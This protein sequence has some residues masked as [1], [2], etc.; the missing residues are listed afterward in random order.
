MKEKM[1]DSFLSLGSNMGERLNNINEAIRLIESSPDNLF[2]LKSEVY[3]SKAMY[4]TELNDFY[5]VVIKIKTLLSPMDLLAFI[6]DIEKKMGRVKGIARYSNRPIDIDILSYGDNVI[7]S[8]DLT[9][10]HP[11]IKERKFVLKPW[12]DI[13]S[14]YI[15]ARGNKKILDLLDETS[16]NSKLLTIKK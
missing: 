12:S 8:K 1:I 3:E 6:K 14:S 2:L 9:I 5:N 15:L 16:D 13:D 7:N 10:P 11:K 4:N